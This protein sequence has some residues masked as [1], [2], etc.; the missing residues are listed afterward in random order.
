MYLE[1]ISELRHAK[2]HFN[3]DPV[4]VDM[5]KI[6][7]EVDIRNMALVFTQTMTNYTLPQTNS[8]PRKIDGWKMKRIN[9]LFSGAI[10]VSGRVSVFS[11]LVVFDCFE[12]F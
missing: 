8:L 4:Q 11:I 3:L 6:S 10:L 1:S 2:H 5:A 7:W 9:V 12:P